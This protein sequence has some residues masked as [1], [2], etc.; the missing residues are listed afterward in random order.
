[1]KTSKSLDNKL[2]PMANSK[3]NMSQQNLLQINAEEGE[4]SNQMTS[5]NKD[6]IFMSVA[7]SKK[8][9]QGSALSAMKPRSQRQKDH[10]LMPTEHFANNT[11]QLKKPPLAPRIEREFNPSITMSSKFSKH[12]GKDSRRGV[13]AY[14]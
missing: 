8:K 5:S 3:D 7:S 2:T 13:N 12:R 6:N 14:Q 4:S 10:L 11:A 1:M 9:K